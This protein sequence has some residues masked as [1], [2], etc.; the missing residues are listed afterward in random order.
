MALVN[1]NGLAAK[2]AWLELPEPGNA[3]NGPKRLQDA[4]I[5]V[6]DDDEYARSG[7]SI[8]IEALGYRA[9]TFASAEDYL[10]SHMSERAACLVLDVHLLGMSGP[11]LQARL[12]ADACCPPIVF[13]TGRFEEHVRK[14]VTELG[15]LGYLTKSGNDKALLDC[16]EKCLSCTSKKPAGDQGPAAPCSER[17]VPVS[18]GARRDVLLRRFVEQEDRSG[19]AREQIDEMDREIVRLQRLVTA[20]LELVAALKGQGQ[21]V[22]EAERALH[23]IRDSLV[24]HQVRR[25]KIEMALPIGTVPRQRTSTA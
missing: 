6:I 7:L 15:A 10:A 23:D 18:D 3:D 13:V 12:V 20:Q 11:D 8:L 9:A 21:S 4:L 22:D 17:R 24:A 16:I 19:A 25:A 2:T 14:R 5:A 1:A